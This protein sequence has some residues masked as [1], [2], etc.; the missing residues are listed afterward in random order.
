MMCKCGLVTFK[1]KVNHLLWPS[2]SPDLH[3]CDSAN[4]TRDV[5]EGTL[6]LLFVPQSQSWDFSPEINDYLTNF[7]IIWEN[8]DADFCDWRVND[9]PWETQTGASAQRLTQTLHVGFFPFNLPPVICFYL[10]LC[11]LRSCALQFMPFF[12]R[13]VLQVT[14][15][16]GTDGPAVYLIMQIP[17][18]IIIRW[19]RWAK[20]EESNK[21]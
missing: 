5:C 10:I 9:D 2:Q 16:Q 8:S 17:V 6:K 14:Q 1:N 3:P 19:P 7:L 12:Y 18:I 4:L 13:L 21:K 15:T 20:R 11:H